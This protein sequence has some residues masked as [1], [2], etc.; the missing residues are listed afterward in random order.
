MSLENSFFEVSPGPFF[1]QIEIPG[2]KSYANRLLILAAL[3]PKPVTLSNLPDSTDVLSMLDCLEKIG[4]KI[5]RNRERVCLL[6]SFPACESDG[7]APILVETGDGGTTTR[8]L[9]ALLALGNRR[10][11]IEPE[12]GMRSRPLEEMLDVLNALSVQTSQNDDA[13]LSLKGPLKIEGPIKVDCSRSTQFASALA[14][15]L[16]EQADLLETARLKTSKSYYQMTLKLLKQAN[17]EEYIVPLDFSSA[18]YP[19]ALAAV[20]GSVI[21]T[22][23]FEKDDYQ[24]DSVFVDVLKRAQAKVEFSSGGLKVEKPQ[25]LVAFEMSCSTCPDL[26]P[27]LAYLASFCAG[28]SRLYDLEVLEHKESDRFLE[29]KNVLDHFGVEY[30]TQG[31]SEILIKGQGHSLS[32]HISKETLTPPADHRIVMMSYLFMRSLNGG[33]LGNTRHVKKS[34]SGFFEVME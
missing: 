24:A 33:L 30:K 14:L 25:K 1:G 21:I 4:I 12:G 26:A 19:L 11:F 6:N 5:E 28:E 20:T 2:S 23:C 27:T 8:F 16:K 10:Y 17:K 31:R 13:W 22:N 34:F 15:V 3:N 18:S 32:K 29:I 9:M 7:Q